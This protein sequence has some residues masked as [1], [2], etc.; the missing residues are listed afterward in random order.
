MDK[1]K[2]QHYV[3]RTYLNQFSNE[4]GDIFLYD[5][6]NQELRIQNHKNVG[7]NKHF[8][9]VEING[10]KDFFIEEYLANQ[11]DV[12]YP[13]LLRKI[14]NH[15]K[16][17]ADDKKKLGLYLAAQHLRTPYQRK[18]Y[19]SMVERTTKE[20]LSRVRKTSLSSNELI[21]EEISELIKNEQINIGVPKEQSL[22]FLMSFVDEMADMLAKQNIIILTASKKSEFLT[23]DNPYVMVKEKW[24]SKWS[25]YGIINTIKI[26]PISP[27]FLI[28]LKDV[29]N[30]T[31]YRPI[32]SSI[33]VRTYNQL[34]AMQSD[35]YI[36]SKNE[37]LLRSIYNRINNVK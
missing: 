8:Y 25:G 6:V 30:K 32:S 18:N 12:L 36:F 35:R 7:Y 33:D 19:N 4:D 21:A 26:F 20:I 1:P 5:N 31:I 3:P 9:T 13:F 22:A 17:N 23:S 28:L 11:V 27:K 37:K 14:T 10:E 29:G 34:I 2:K 15:E 16:F 24:A